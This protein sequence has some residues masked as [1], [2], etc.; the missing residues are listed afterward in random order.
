[1]KKFLLAFLAALLL[2]CTG[3]KAA[4]EPEQDRIAGV[5]K[6][7]YG[8]TEYRFNQNGTM[9]IEALN[10]GSFK[11]TYSIQGSRITIQYKIVVKNVKETYDYRIDGDTLYLDDQV[12]KR[13]E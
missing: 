9:K 13:K 2:L 12:F 7:S 4:P 3:C 10:F 5:W 6:D 1:M 8:L 11:G